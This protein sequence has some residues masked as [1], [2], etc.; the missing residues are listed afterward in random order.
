MNGS[1]IADSICKP[2][3]AELFAVPQFSDTSTRKIGMQ[4]GR[5]SHDIVAAVV[6]Q[7]PN[8]VMAP[9][10][11]SLIS[12]PKILRDKSVELPCQTNFNFLKKKNSN[13]D[14]ST[15]TKPIACKPT[16]P[17]AIMSTN[18]NTSTPVKQHPQHTQP[19]PSNFMTMSSPKQPNPFVDRPPIKLEDFEMGKQLGKGKFG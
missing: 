18:T 15:A 12:S 17:Q 6:K 19:T 1:I 8:F 16:A 2:K 11:A 10:P 5:A 3:T 7:P 13:R 9:P 14:D 4:S